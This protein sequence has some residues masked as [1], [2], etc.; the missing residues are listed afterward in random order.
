[1]KNRRVFDV[2]FVVFAFVVLSGCGAAD[3]P[4][5]TQ[6]L[7]DA[8]TRP[9]GDEIEL[10]PPPSDETRI[11]VLGD[12]Q[13]GMNVMPP[14]RVIYGEI[15][16]RIVNYNPRFVFIAG[17]LVEAGTQENWD[18]FCVQIEANLPSSTIIYP[19]IGNHDV[20]HD[21]NLER[22]FAKF[23]YLGNQRY[24]FVLAGRPAKAVFIVLDV[25]AVHNPAPAQNWEAQKTWVDSLLD[26]PGYAD[27]FKF[28]VFHVPHWTDGARSPD[29]VTRPNFYVKELDDIFFDAGTG[30]RRVHA[31]FQGHTHAY[32]RWNIN[33]IHYFVSGGGGAGLHGL[34]DPSPKS[35]FQ[36]SVHNYLKLKITPT[37]TEVRPWG[38]DAMGVW[39]PLDEVIIIPK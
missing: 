18:S 35:Q 37:F 3:D 5:D 39:G 24:Y 36:A 1:M 12:T 33:G 21:P 9:L 14:P 16:P 10:P 23:E 11:I 31:V 22:Y 32:E 25:S 15:V 8:G 38:R 4:V 29:P 20:G 13:T 19:V 34:R 28:V 27:L 17:D 6:A 26:N 30:V 2:V 7:L